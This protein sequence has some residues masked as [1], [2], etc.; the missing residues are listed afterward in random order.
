MYVG[1]TKANPHQLLT[2]ACLLI[3]AL[4][5]GPSRLLGKD[6]VDETE[7]RLYGSSEYFASYWLSPSRRKHSRFNRVYSD[8]IMYG[9][10]CIGSGWLAVWLRNG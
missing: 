7:E 4:G 3:N 8:I 2:R 5:L 1:L 10:M 6:E 9:Q